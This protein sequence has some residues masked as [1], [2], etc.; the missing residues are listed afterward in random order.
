MTKVPGRIW[1]IRFLILYFV[2]GS[3]YAWA[4]PLLETP[5]ELRHFGM[6]EHLRQERTLPIQDPDHSDTIYHQEGSQPPLYYLAATFIG[7]PFDFSDAPRLR[8]LNPHAKLGLPHVDDNK[9]IVLRDGHLPV[10][11]Q[12]AIAAYLLRFVGLT[13]GA[14]TIVFVYLTALT[15]SRRGDVALLAA[16][17]TA[18]NPM[19][20][21]IMA[22]VTN[23][24][25]VTTL[26]SIV[27]FLNVRMLRDGFDT[28][29][30]LLIA[31]TL[32]LATLTKLSGLALVPVVAA[33]G[34][35]VAYRKHDL[36]GLF[37]LGVMVA[38]VWLV[39]AGW[40]YARNVILYGEL[41][42]TH[43]MVAIVGARDETFTLGTLL[44]EFEGF[45]ITYWSAFGSVNILTH[46]IFYLIMD[47][48]MVLAGIGMIWTL[49][50]QR[51]N[52]E[53]MILFG[54]LILTLAIG[55]ISLINW[56]SQ[57]MASQGRLLFPY[58]AAIS[59]LIAVG[60]M[61]IIRFRAAAAV[62]IGTLTVYTLI[63]PFVWIAPRY[64]PP[65]PLETLPEHVTPVFA[66]YGD[67]DLIGYHAPDARYSSGDEVEITLYWRPRE[68]SD[69]DYSLYIHA[70]DIE[71][72]VIGKVDT[73]PGGGLL[74][75]TTWE[76]DVIYEDS[77]RIPIDGNGAFGLR[78]QVG[79]WHYPSEELLRA[80]DENARSIDSVILEAGGFVD[81]ALESNYGQPLSDPISFGD[82]IAL[83]DYTFEDHL[84]LVWRTLDTPDED[85]TVFVQLLTDSDEIIAQ[86]D[87]PPALP[88][89]FWQPAETYV[90]QHTLTAE[91]FPEDMP[92]RLIVGW[93]R[94]NDF[95]RLATSTPDNAHVLMLHS[96]ETQN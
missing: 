92:Y 57:T 29:R 65:H 36:G 62:L 5:D 4:T 54:M 70:L 25:L 44:L 16:G 53:Q 47:V 45:R 73:Y 63:T 20:I 48:L 19:F 66:R 55:I 79:W 7:L 38:G 33:S 50:K 78:V 31:I 40:W 10:L 59:T 67:I 76:S 75:T 51:K 28:R 30:G 80:E 11:T 89:R 61:Q 88:T 13:L 35:W 87:A 14:I 69:R 43:T 41:F 2:I 12:A 72:Q 1:I 64:T 27:I 96:P 77:Y 6:V 71:G 85:Y 24:T 8:E 49:Y 68:V 82:V 39:L 84:T 34:L 81:I 18:F 23:D 86:A 93:Y 91:D 94:P 60:L 21:F 9:N 83:E 52:T 74:R 90:T 42:G 3:A 32:A 37:R 95:L 58:I 46:P 15:I 17:I 26:I 22:S 56:T